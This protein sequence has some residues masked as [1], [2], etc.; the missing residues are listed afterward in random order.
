MRNYSD[1]F[2]SY[3][4]VFI[5][6]LSLV[7]L[8]YLPS[9]FHEA[10]SD[11]SIPYLCHIF[12]LLTLCVFS[13]LFTPLPGSVLDV[14]QLWSCCSFVVV[15]LWL[16]FQLWMWISFGRCLIFSRGSALVVVQLCP[17]RSLEPFITS[18]QCWDLCF[19][20]L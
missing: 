14:A 3:F 17:C 15:Q 5:L 2:I 7:R 1:L 10:S 6:F 9:V 19:S 8:I 12:P 16:W 20:E 13:T 4:S 18:S 11:L